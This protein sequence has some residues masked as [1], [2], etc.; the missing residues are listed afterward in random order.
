MAGFSKLFSTLWGGSL[1]GRFEASAVF[2]VALSLCDQNGALDMTPEAI[3]GTTGWP[4]DFIRKGLAELV[5]P[6]SRSRTPGHGGRR[7]LP[8][9]E[10][11]DWGW[12]ITN[13]AKY[14]DQMRSIERRE[15]LAEAKRRERA[16]KKSTLVNKSTIVNQ[17]QP[18]T[19]AEAEADIE[20]KASLSGKPA[21]VA[22]RVLAFLNQK[23]GKAF[24]PTDTN[25]GLI[26]ARLKEG[27]DED[28]AHMVIARKVRDWKDDDKMVGFLRP[29]TLFNREKFNQYAGE[30]GGV[31]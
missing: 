26:R 1:Y 21:D 14:R 10:H 16:N 19:E 2:M 15:Y 23:T 18:I 27:Y 6:D 7:L 8:L 28:M 31:R 25:L 22:R 17:N 5:E 3:A 11:R 13:Y 30:C 9:D 4:C 20:A 29:S 12:Q 24:R